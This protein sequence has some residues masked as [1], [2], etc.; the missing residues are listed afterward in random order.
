MADETPHRKPVAQ[1]VLDHPKVA[2]FLA[3]VALA[4]SFSPKA[5]SLASWICL[6]IA[7]VFG[8]AMLLGIVEKLGWGPAKKIT[9]IFLLVLFICAF[10]MWLTDGKKTIENWYVATL[11]L[12]PVE[13]PAPLLPKVS[14]NI[15]L[16]AKATWEQLR[17]DMKLPEQ[18]SKAQ[19]IFHRP[20]NQ[21]GLP[22]LT[23]SAVRIKEVVVNN[24][25]ETARS[26][27]WHIHCTII[28]LPPIPQTEDRVWQDYI[29]TMRDIGPVENDLGPGD[30]RWYTDETPTLSTDE[31]MNLRNGIHHLYLTG[32]AL[33]RDSSG[34]DFI[35]ELCIYV[36]SEGDAIVWHVCQNHNRV[37]VRDRKR[38]S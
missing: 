1:W 6:A 2:G 28:E 10:G 23:N 33:Y 9:S 20:E 29:A 7:V 11:C 27:R 5:S 32:L 31:A 37:G 26:F 34:L 8:I 30:F 16:T 17:N 15:Q 18:Y 22:Y 14:A 13:V 24:G 12:N 4:I 21:A 25:P 38:P 36:E 19:V 35:S 3:A